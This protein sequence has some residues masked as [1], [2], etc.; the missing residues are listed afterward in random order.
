VGTR[1]LHN[2]DFTGMFVGF[3]DLPPD[4]LTQGYKGM[5]KALKKYVEG[6]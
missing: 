3:A 6:Q 5:N 4:V 1:L 2:E